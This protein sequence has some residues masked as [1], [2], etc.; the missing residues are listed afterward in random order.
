MQRDEMNYGK[1]FFVSILA[2][3]F[4]F[5]GCT[6]CFAWSS[7]LTFWEKYMPEASYY[8]PIFAP[9]PQD[10][11]AGLS[12]GPIASSEALKFESMNDLLKPGYLAIENGYCLK[13]DGKGFVAVRTEFPGA[14]AEMI[15]WWFWWH[16][17][18]DVRYK[19]WCPGAH[20][21]IGVDNMEQ[22]KDASL[23]YR[24]RYLNNPQYPVE[25]VGTGVRRLSIRFISPEDFG[26]D[27]SRFKEMGI[28]AVVCGVVGD[29]IAGAT[30]EHTYMVH[31]FRRTAN[32]LE[33]RSRFWIGEALESYALRKLMITQDTVKGVA[34]HCAT[35][36][37]HLA[38][39]LPEIFEEFK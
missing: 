35:E 25:D 17:F 31:M 22:M 2:L 10:V 23:S 21:A 1:G 36:Y 9:L 12:N 5:V 7:D 3:L 11:N 19:I 37:N 33:L 8:D 26:F 29:R 20:Y 24:Q 16:A 6:S 14:S 28:E 18:K 30:V 39:F 34:F 32:G 38:E 13:P 15:H 27:T 4:V